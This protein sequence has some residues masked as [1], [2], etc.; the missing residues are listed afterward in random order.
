MAATAK[1]LLSALLA[2]TLV[3][4]FTPIT[5]VA[6]N[7]VDTFDQS[8]ISDIPAATDASSAASAAPADAPAAV[9][10]NQTAPEAPA[11]D[12][13]PYA[14]PASDG[15]AAVAGGV[16][17]A[18]PA[19]TV[20]P[21]ENPAQEVQATLS[22]QAGTV[23]D[24]VTF[25]VVPPN[26]DSSSQYPPDVTVP[27]GA[28]YTISDKNWFNADGSY[29][30]DSD[31]DY[32]FEGGKTYKFYVDVT[33]DDDKDFAD[34][35][36]VAVNGGTLEGT[37]DVYNSP[38]SGF[39]ALTATISV[40]VTSDHGTYTDEQGVEFSYKK[41][42]GTVQSGTDN[43]AITH[44][45]LPNDAAAG[46]I[47]VQVPSTMEGLVV[48]SLGADDADMTIE[49]GGRM[50]SIT[51]PAS[52]EAICGPYFKDGPYNA[53]DM[54]NLT[55]VTF[56][57]GSKVTE[58]P[59]EVFA[60]SG[61]TSI[62]LPDGMTAIGN[63]VFMNCKS[64]V[65]IDVPSRVRTIGDKAFYNCEA[66]VDIK[67][68][69]G[70]SS[71]GA[72]AFASDYNNMSYSS[73]AI[74]NSV[75]SIGENA[76]AASL[77]SVSLGTSMEDSRLQTI[78]ADAFAGTSL[79]SV[80]IPNSVESIG[81]RAFACAFVEGVGA[82]GHGVSTLKEVTFG[83]S[84][85]DSNLQTIGPNAFGASALTT[86]TLPNGLQTLET[87]AYGLNNYDEYI[88]NGPFSQS[89]LLE[90]IVWPTKPGLNAVSGF[91]GCDALKDA[92]VSS[93]P[94]WMTSIEAGAFSTGGF[95]NIEIP[96]GI[97]S[98]GDYAFSHNEIESIV[99]SEAGGALA[100]GAHAFESNYQ[101][102]EG[103]V[104]DLPMRVS[105]IG[106]KAFSGL[107]TNVESKS[108]P[109]E[110]ETP[111]GTGVSYE[112]VTLFTGPTFV[113]HNP[114]IVIGTSED[115]WPIDAARGA[116]VRYPANAGESFM[117]FKTAVEAAEAQLEAGTFNPTIFEVIEEEQPAVVQHS[118]SV[119]APAGATMQL[120]VNGDEIS[121]PTT[122]SPLTAKADEGSQVAVVVSLEGYKDYVA[123]PK[124]G[125]LLEDWSCTV[126][127]S[128]LTPLS[129][130][131]SITV[132][133]T[134]PG[135]A[136]QRDQVAALLGSTV[137]VFDA[138]GRLVA[139]D[140]ASTSLVVHV[141]DLAPG[142]YT[143]LAF[144]KND[145]FNSVNSLDD[146]ARLGVKDGSWA[147]GKAT[148]KP[149]KD[150]ALTFAVPDL[151][152][153]S[154][155]DILTSGSVYVPNSQ[156]V[157]DYTFYA[158]ID[159]AMADGHA[160]DTLTVGV[161][162]GV[163]LDGG[164][165]TEGNRYGMAGYDAAAREL[166]VSLKG[167][168]RQSGSL[169]VG[170]KVVDPGS[171]SISA[172][173]T[174][175]AVTAP[176]GSA[177]VEA[178]GLTLAVPE[179]ELTSPEFKVGVHAAPGTTVHFKIGDTVLDTTATT[180]MV[181]IGAA[182]LTIPDAELMKGY[183]S[184]YGVTAMLQDAAG[185]VTTQVS[186]TVDYPIVAF[187]THDV[188]EWELSF[189]HAG[190]EVF[191][192]KDGQI[193]DHPYYTVVM[194]THNPLYY[195][196]SWPFRSVLRSK[197]PLASTAKLVLGMLDGT[198]KY[199]DMQLVS[200]TP[201][202]EGVYSYVYEAN[203]PIGTGNPALD[204][205][206]RDIPTGFEVVP[207][208]S[209]NG[210]EWPEI[211]QKNM[212]AMRSAMREPLTVKVDWDM[213]AKDTGMKEGAET[214]FYYQ[215]APSAYEY[216][217]GQG[218]DP[219]TGNL[220]GVCV[221]GG[222]YKHE[223]WDPDGSVWKGLTA[224]ERQTL[225]EFEDAMGAFLKAWQELVG[226][227]KPM[228]E[229]GSIDEYLDNEFNR[230]TGTGAPDPGALESDGWQV[231]YNA[232][233]VGGDEPDWY[234]VHYTPSDDFGVDMVNGGDPTKYT[235]SVTPENLIDYGNNMNNGGSPTKYQNLVDP[236]KPVSPD[237]GTGT[238]EVVQVKNDTFDKIN[239]TMND[240]PSVA[241]AAVS[242]AQ[243]QLGKK[244]SNASTI[245]AQNGK[246]AGARVA[247]GA[248]KLT[249]VTS[250]ATTAIQ[251]HQNH[252]TMAQLDNRLYDYAWRSFDLAKD[253]MS[254]GIVD[255]EC[256]KAM[257]REGIALLCAGYFNLER[258]TFLT[259]DN[260]V[261][262]ELTTL[263]I[264][265]AENPA[266]SKLVSEVGTGWTALTQLGDNFVL[267]PLAN[268]S[269]SL[270][271]KFA[272]QRIEDCI[273]GRKTAHGANVIVDPSGWV[274]EGVDDN[275][276]E[277]VTATVYQLVDGAWQKWDAA[278][279]NQENSQSTSS[280]G[281]YGWDVPQG[282]WKIV[283]EKDGYDTE[284]IIVDGVLKDVAETD[285]MDVLPEYRNIA[286][287]LISLIAPTVESVVLDGDSI[288]VTFSQYMKTASPIQ[289][290]TTI[291]GAPVS[292]TWDDPV[293]G[294]NEK[295]DLESLTKVL[296]IPVPAGA[297]PGSVLHVALSGGVNYANKPFASTQADITLPGEAPSYYYVEPVEPAAY[298]K[299]SGQALPFTFKR[300]LND[301][302]TFPNFQGITVDGT[303]VDQANYTVE[304]GSAIITLAAAYLETLSEGSHTLSAQFVDGSAQAPFSVQ[305][306]ATPTP[307]PG[308]GEET[309][310]PDTPDSGSKATDSSETKAAASK[311]AKTKATKAKTP[312]TGEVLPVALFAGAALASAL[313]LAL[314]W[315]QRRPSFGKHARR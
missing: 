229:Y 191:L 175:G 112:S 188:T 230:E 11:V 4:A 166:A 220:L 242:E 34:S 33:A 60:G 147:S 167:A 25:I 315:R 40:T 61:L 201:G 278:A 2:F 249:G 308:P 248:S 22:T 47:D 101:M 117:A 203:V 66:L 37:P 162:E 127:E 69:E 195:Q 85:A 250:V 63:S 189:K 223:N 121:K 108:V 165:Y 148:V 6:E 59:A 260:V 313:V 212:V 16:D 286:V 283:F 210:F 309:V 261:S 43:C 266:A 262:A 237:K 119:S 130:V 176:L 246:T 272:E 1:K 273:K 306:E 289:P 301:E 13:T 228:D 264:V 255:T 65:A 243:N 218:I 258:R 311:S 240:V 50:R 94:T 109:V 267:K 293:T 29:K 126:K 42:A 31:P 247:A 5:A 268:H 21:T 92:T 90:T 194:S 215:Y 164:A 15:G 20:T 279:Y 143:V 129:D 192:V 100:I 96:E 231:Y 56:E 128:D 110:V 271:D 216:L 245:M 27:S 196:A 8:Q 227:K 282:T 149:A 207:E 225:T 200:A 23:I 178:P 124:D 38:E 142:S 134:K 135:K 159:Y 174:S 265:L 274:Y 172:S 49:N 95:S 160:A 259:C 150:A 298:T 82:K 24:S 10:E 233:P 83:T 204:L 139:Q 310:V 236:T 93:L 251:M 154:A 111:Y 73:I 79:T 116:T 275:R 138:Q 105:S 239:R 183:V 281:I 68:H 234:G 19:G 199:Y 270:V 157:P 221:F 291:D 163:E 181:G 170:L 144:E 222:A 86:V 114:D 70:L 84:Q 180:N 211:T 186:K 208:F 263:S 118:I 224:D 161:P 98:V 30:E 62:T 226:A 307:A 46:S 36:T 193:I 214:D 97:T 133:L 88:T 235:N 238:I 177:T 26:A 280:W 312:V 197:K 107:W 198:V 9:P 115:E 3:F 244:L 179:V 145:Y 120:A 294:R 288:V 187:G 151:Q 67:L 89:P 99:I 269:K 54:S 241:V 173:V 64:L 103:T 276:L 52:V 295:G 123:Q 299:S 137:A 296:R 213:A 131:G 81:A 28:S 44:I 7:P 106:A 51:I 232:D 290:A 217:V 168:D 122:K 152:L 58:L 72:N 77:K 132:T 140:K 285:E 302:K 153:L 14:Q 219:E 155:G 169:Y 57:K 48:S 125:W 146:F 202:I 55:T 156:V 185:N 141:K 206:S 104:I 253:L 39:S 205:T 91:N 300:T 35:A 45:Y 257:M 303:A 184:L 32:T 287:G 71:I 74:P 314:A 80:E 18:A 254:D 297:E 136:T 41:L 17:A 76:F 171:Y 53:G 78:G 256:G 158:R 277:G 284:A 209:D 87:D 75:E 305:A 304:A 102:G 190:R 182:T 12:P 113:I 252:I 292:A